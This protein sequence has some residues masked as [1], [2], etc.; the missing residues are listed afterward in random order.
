MLRAQ[1]IAVERHAVSADGTLIHPQ[2]LDSYRHRASNSEK[3]SASNVGTGHDQVAAHFDVVI[4]A[5]AAGREELVRLHRSRQIDDETLH[6]LERDLD[7]EEM[8][9]I[10]GKG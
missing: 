1:L 7:L 9:A 5:V 2:L 3:L 10:A 6:D 4:A 8:S